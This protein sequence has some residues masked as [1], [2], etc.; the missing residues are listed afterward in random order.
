MKHKKFTNRMHI[1]KS[2]EMLR[3]R[4]YLKLFYD[5]LDYDQDNI[6]NVSKSIIFR[7]R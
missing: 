5:D 7:Q 4:E 2:L 3:L 1:V 6:Y